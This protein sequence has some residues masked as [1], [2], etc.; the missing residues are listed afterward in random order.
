MKKRIY[1]II[2]DYL[3]ILAIC[4]IPLIIYTMLKDFNIFEALDSK[5]TIVMILTIFKDLTFRNASIGKK[6]MKIEI[7]KRDNKVPTITTIIIRNITVAIWPL[8]CILILMKKDRL[9]DL[10]CDTKIIEIIDTK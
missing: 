7:R 6:I 8:E 2:I 1:A 3:I 5:I 10:M 9:G 4:Q